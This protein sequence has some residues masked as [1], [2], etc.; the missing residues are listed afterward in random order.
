MQHPFVADHRFRGAAESHLPGLHHVGA[1]AVLHRQSG[2]LLDEQHGHALGVEFADDAEDLQHHQ[3]GQPQAGFVEQQQLRAAHERPGDGEHLLFSSRERA[4]HL[5]AA[6]FQP[7]KPDVLLLD[8]GPDA[9]RVTARVGAQFQVVLH[10]LAGQHLPPFRALRDAQPHRLV[11]RQ[12]AQVSPGKPDVALAGPQHARHG[13]QGGGLA[14][15]VGSD[16]GHDLALL[17]AQRNATHR[18]NRAV[19]HAQIFDFQQGHKSGPPQVRW[20]GW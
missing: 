8:V 3:R 14:R 2:I 16:Q 7:G 13:P 1:V 17:N 4:G 18:L 19:V 11:G 15:A 10:A 12:S 20:W 5:V 9:G 6:L